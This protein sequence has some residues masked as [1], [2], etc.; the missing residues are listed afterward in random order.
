MEESANIGVKIKKWRKKRELTQDALARKANIPYTSLA[1]IESGVIENPS[2]KT[3]SKI[4]KGLDV[5]ID[6]LIS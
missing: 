6:D 2:I 3:V 5:C 1:K 4:A